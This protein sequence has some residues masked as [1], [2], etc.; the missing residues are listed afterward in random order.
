MRPPPIRPRGTET[1][2]PNRYEPMRLEL[3]PGEDLDPDTHF[4]RDASRSV[5]AENDS[6]DLGFR[7]SL[8]PYR[9]CEHGCSYC[10]GPDTPVLHADMVWKPIGDVQVGDTLIGFDEYPTPGRPRR[11][12]P[13][14]VERVWWSKRET[15]RLVTGSREVVTTAEHRWLQARTF[16][17]SRTRELAAGSNLRVLPVAGGEREGEDYRAGYVAGTSPGDGTTERSTREYRRGFVAGFFD[18]E[19]SSGDSLRISQVD[20]GALERVRS[21]AA[22]LGFQLQMEPREGCASALRLVGS[23]AERMRFFGVFRPAIRRKIDW[24]FGHEPPTTPEAIERIEPGPPR[25]VVDIQ[26]S[27][28]TFYAAG[29]ATHNC[30]ARPSHERLGWSAGLDFERRILV[31]AEA[32][33][34]LRRELAA[35][36]WQPQVVALSGN[37]DCYQPVERK[38]EITRRCLEVFADFRNPVSVITKSALVAR[39]VDHLAVLAGFAAARVMVSITTLDPELARRMEPRASQPKRRL[40]AIRTL[41]ETG[42][43]VGV[44]IGP[45]IPGLNDMEIPK[46]LEHAAAAG[47]RSA[48]WVL[49]RLARPLDEIFADWLER[50]YPEKKKRVLGHIRETR[51]GRIS[52]SRFHHRQRGQG[53]YAEQIASLF[54]I[55]SRRHGLDGGFVP[56]SSASFRRPQA[57]TGQL[58]LF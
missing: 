36:K 26:T 8:N 50:N 39:D 28:R 24:V 43:P 25:D 55:A 48:S 57:G 1:N 19:G 3:E 56:L 4:Y 5:L 20:R 58:G 15:L 45:V 11:L 44:M 47:A 2:T 9:G 40:E 12:R 17:W 35:P 32:P 21:Y 14:V 38:L 6:P 18:A 13:S 10:L 23:L 30:Y 49:L 34:L 37:T 46:I 52:D 22:A 41:A 51:G 31:K 27:T 7:Y 16:R 54:A 29:L 53:I 42:V 33:E